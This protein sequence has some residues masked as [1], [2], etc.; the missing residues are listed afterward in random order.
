MYLFQV[1]TASVDLPGVP[2]VDHFGFN[3]PG[4]C[5]EVIAFIAIEISTEATGYPGVHGAQLQERCELVQCQQTTG[6]DRSLYALAVPSDSPSRSHPSQTE[7]RHH[8]SPELMTERC[9]EY[10][11]F[12]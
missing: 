7:N 2:K 12:L 3:K 9:A 6:S 1:G 11:G 10:E 5:E 8:M 4:W